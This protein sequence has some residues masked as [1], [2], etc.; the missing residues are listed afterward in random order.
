MTQNCLLAI[1][2]PGFGELLQSDKK[3]VIYDVVWANFCPNFSEHCLKYSLSALSLFEGLLRKF[4]LLWGQFNILQHHHFL[5]IIKV[6]CR[7]PS[8]A[9]HLP[10]R[11]QK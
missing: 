6:T 2:P 1:F 4:H 3:K 5:K 8:W 10:S 7:S 11:V 9:T